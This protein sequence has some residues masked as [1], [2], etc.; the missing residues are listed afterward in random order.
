MDGALDRSYRRDSFDR[1]IGGA[2]GEELGIE[3]AV[4]AAD[5]STALVRLT[6]ERVRRLPA[7]AFEGGRKGLPVHKQR[8][9]AFA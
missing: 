2:S 3:I 1:L 7:Y 6:E 4:S 9:G 5:P 8:Q